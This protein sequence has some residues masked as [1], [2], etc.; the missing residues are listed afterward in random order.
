MRQRWGILDVKEKDIEGSIVISDRK[1]Q[2]WR[3]RR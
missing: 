2:L 3:I 1:E